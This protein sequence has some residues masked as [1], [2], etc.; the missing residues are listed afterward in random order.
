MNLIRIIGLA[1]LIVTVSRAQAVPDYFDM[2]ATRVRLLRNQPGELHIDAQGITFRSADNKTSIT[3]PIQD[4]READVADP[5]SLRFQ[6]YEVQKWKP[7]ERREY[8]FRVAVEA[9]VESLAQFL[10][11]RINRPVVGHYASR[12][13][14]QTLAFH[15]RT[16]GGT[17]GTLEIGNEAI[18]FVSDKPSDSRT[19]L[20]RDIETIGRPDAYRFRVTTNRETYVVELKSELPEAAYEFAWS[21]VYNL[22]KENA[23]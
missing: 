20:Y 18:R 1:T 15:R 17:H 22:E 21:K 5:R 10:A 14:F 2:K 12:S 3:V 4:L 13:K 16:R 7:I 19:W 6:T 11:E 9:P 23:K 8:V